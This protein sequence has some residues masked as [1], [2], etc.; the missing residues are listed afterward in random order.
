MQPEQ[1]TPSS[2]AYC[3]RPL[4]DNNPDPDFCLPTPPTGQG[5]QASCQQAWARRWADPFTVYAQP[6]PWPPTDPDTHAVRLAITRAAA[7]QLGVGDHSLEVNR[8]DLDAL[9]HLAHHHLVTY[10]IPRGR[11]FGRVVVDWFLMRERVLFGRDVEPVRLP[12]GSRS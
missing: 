12:V 1:L 6:Q 4:P 8:H 10:A 9:D 5:D 7:H 11:A 2:C 3:G